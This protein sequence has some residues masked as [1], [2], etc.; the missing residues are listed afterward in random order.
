MFT[1]E[2]NSGTGTT[3][4][5]PAGPGNTHV[6]PQE[7]PQNAPSDCNPEN[8]AVAGVNP[9]LVMKITTIQEYISMTLSHIPICLVRVHEH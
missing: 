3:A 5:E 8:V 6:Q 7:V 9:R 4:A 1:G 2:N